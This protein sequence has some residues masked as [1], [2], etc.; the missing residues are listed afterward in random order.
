MRPRSRCLAGLM[1]ALSGAATTPATGGEPAGTA[2]DH[3]LFDANHCLTAIR[4]SRGESAVEFH[5]GCAKMKLITISCVFD[6]TGYLGLGP[7]FARPGWH[8]NHPLPVLADET[9]RRI[10]D[11]AISDPDGPAVWAAC[12][13]TDLGDFASRPKPYHGTACYGAMIAI[14]GVVNDTG[15]DPQMVADELLPES[16]SW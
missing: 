3:A 4:P 15:R 10:S 2:I 6:R 9:G 1:L 14:T 7:R 13:V 5:W 8:C 16:G 12:A 11:V